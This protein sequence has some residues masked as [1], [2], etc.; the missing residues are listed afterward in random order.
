METEVRKQKYRN[1]VQKQSTETKYRN[2]AF[3]VLLTHDCAQEKGDCQVSTNTVL[4]YDK[5]CVAYLG[6][7]SSFVAG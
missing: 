2:E 5:V 6:F 7:G 3:S 4:Q 1:K